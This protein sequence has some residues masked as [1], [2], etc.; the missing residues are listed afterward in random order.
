MSSINDQITKI[1]QFADLKEGW[2]SYGAKPV[3]Q[4]AID[5]AMRL[6]YLFSHESRVGPTNNGGVY[7]WWGDEEMTIE[8]SPDGHI[9]VSLEDPVATPR[10]ILGGR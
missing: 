1:R 3:A 5:T 6:A 2:D 10:Q 9:E 4:T 7:F 8:I